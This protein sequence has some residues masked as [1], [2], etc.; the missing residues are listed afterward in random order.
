MRI[1]GI[2]IPNEKRM[3]IA[4]THLY[5]IG[6]TNVYPVLKAAGIDPA[7]RAKTL[8]EIEVGKIQKVLEETKIEGNLKREIFNNIKRLKELGTYR[9]LRHIH[10]LPSRGQ[11]TRR[12]AR[13]KRGKRVTIG[14]I[15]KELA[16]KMGTPTA[17]PA[18]IKK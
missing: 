4:L 11:N 18:E 9:G 13:T 6:R 5:G 1:S 3:D 16:Q 10:N 7:K 15:N 14:A 12:N 17:K 8:T 2:D